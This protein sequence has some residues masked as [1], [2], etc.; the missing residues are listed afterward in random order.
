MSTQ[1]LPHYN[2]RLALREGLNLLSRV[3]KLQ[4]AATWFFRFVALGIA[5]D[6]ILL[7]ASRLNPIAVTPIVLIV[8]PAVLGI[9]GLL[10]AYIWRLPIERVAARADTVLGLKERLTTAL[11]LQ[12]GQGAHPLAGLQLHDAVEQ[13]RRIEPLEHAL[14]HEPLRQRQ[15]HQ[16]AVHARVAVELVDQGEQQ[17]LQRCVFVVALVGERQGAVQ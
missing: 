9:V 14:D 15:L 4:L 8:P 12:R 10:V 2:D 13:V 5:M 11:E 16:D 6:C 17:M 1:A 7:G 3:I